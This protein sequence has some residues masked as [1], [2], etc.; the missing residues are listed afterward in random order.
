MADSRTP[1]I[2]TSK[3]AYVRFHGPQGT[4]SG[5]YSD[6]VLKGWAYKIVEWKKSR[7]QSYI[8]FNNDIGGFAPRNALTLK[9]F[10]YD[11]TQ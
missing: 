4:Y 6:D 11:L 10:V 3:V 5:G 2:L 7:I 1:E 8:Y 9:K